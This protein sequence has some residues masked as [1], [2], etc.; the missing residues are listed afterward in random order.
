M[1]TLL[2]VCARGKERRWMIDLLVVEIICISSV[3]GKH[4]RCFL[5]VTWRI[6]ISWGG[7]TFCLS[8]AAIYC[9]SRNTGRYNYVQLTLFSVYMSLPSAALFSYCF[10]SIFSTSVC[11]FIY[12][13]V[14]EWVRLRNETL[15]FCTEMPLLWVP[16]RDLINSKI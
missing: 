7:I 4:R 1:N 9:L 8:G 10:W 5:T 2:A 6:M 14:C 11:L 13:C 3:H 16:W 15:T 12:F